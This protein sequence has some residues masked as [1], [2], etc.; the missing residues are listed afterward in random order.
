MGNVIGAVKW[1]LRAESVAIVIAALLL[2]SQYE[3]SWSLFAVL[4]LFPDLSLFAY[5]ISN[6]VGAI[7][8][9]AAHS[10]IGALFIASLGFVNELPVF[11]ISGLVWIAHIGFDRAL[12]YGLKYQRGFGCTHLGLVGKAKQS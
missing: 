4:F 5:L 10:L 8:Y 6:K 11:Q 7:A 1:T 3:F 9:N 12:G 2:Y